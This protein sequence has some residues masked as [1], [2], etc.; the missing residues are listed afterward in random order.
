MKKSRT[1]LAV[2]N[3]RNGCNCAQAVFVAYADMFGID[4]AAAMRLAS[5]FGGGMG[6]MRQVC[7]AVSAMSMVCGLYNGA[8]RA[9]DV[10]ARQ[11]NYNT[12]KALA[13]RFAEL[14]GSVRCGQLLGLEPGLPEGYSKKPCV[15]YVRSCAALLDELLFFDDTLQEAVDE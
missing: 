11:A 8:E 6:G 15:E 9:G 2:D 1:E 3:F 5:S 13:G 10:K 14:H 4:N 12:V 7:G